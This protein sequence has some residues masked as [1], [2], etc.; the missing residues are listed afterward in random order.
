MKLTYHKVNIAPFLQANQMPVDAF[1]VEL[2]DTWW[3]PDQPVTPDK[4]TSWVKGTGEAV[5]IP[6]VPY[7]VNVDPPAA[8][9]HAAQ[10]GAQ[11]LAELPTIVSGRVVQLHLSIGT[12]VENM[13]SQ[14]GPLLRYYLG[15]G[16]IV[17]G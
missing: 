14:Q 8:M 7:L 4:V 16:C 15:L 13:R 5:R 17:K 11:A 3:Y 6:L 10:I 12:P 2:K 9:A 1:E